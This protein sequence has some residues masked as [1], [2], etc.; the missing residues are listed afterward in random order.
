MRW[1]RVEVGAGFLLVVALALYW[2]DQGV[3]QWALLGCAVHE[4]GHLVALRLLGG[5]LRCLRLGGVGAEM[6]IQGQLSYR[7][8]IVLALSG[9]LANFLVVLV[10]ARCGRGHLFCGINLVL[11]VLNLLPVARLDGGRALYALC[12][13]LMGTE[14]AGT[15][16]RGLDWCCGLALLASGVAILVVGGSFTLLLFAV[17]VLWTQKTWKFH[18]KRLA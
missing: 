4:I 17:W 15:L 7:G 3:V 8:E 9:P 13:M 1:G 5:R 6:I 18:K 16:C 10:A 14:R 11:G 2:D 12:C